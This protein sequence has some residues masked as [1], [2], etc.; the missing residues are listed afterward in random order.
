[1]LGETHDFGDLLEHFVKHP[2]IVGGVLHD[3]RIAAICVAH[4]VEALATL[5]RHFSLFPELKTCDQFE[6]RE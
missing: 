2:H 4:G 3:A 5:N 6:A 1:M